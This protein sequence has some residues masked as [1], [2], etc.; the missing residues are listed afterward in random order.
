MKSVY[1]LLRHEPG[2]TL[3]HEK[4]THRALRRGMGPTGPPGS[5]AIF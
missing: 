2:L 5:G 4:G 3:A 1:A